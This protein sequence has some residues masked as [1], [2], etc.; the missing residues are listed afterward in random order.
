MKFPDI[1]QSYAEEFTEWP[2]DNPH[3]PLL[4]SQ[5]YQRTLESLGIGHEDNVIISFD[6]KSNVPNK[7]IRVS[8]RYPNFLDSEPQPDLPPEG[9][10]NPDA[11]P[12]SNERQPVHKSTRK[13]IC[14]INYCWC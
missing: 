10:Y 6:V 4:I 7:P 13:R 14:S 5:V 11:P 8:I 9:F 1:N 12:N 3:I 2:L